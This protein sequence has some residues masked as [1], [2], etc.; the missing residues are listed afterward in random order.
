MP[1]TTVQEFRD[2][3]EENTVA[4]LDDVPKCG[5]VGWF[6]NGGFMFFEAFKPNPIDRFSTIFK[7]SDSLENFVNRAPR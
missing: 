6:G 5:T 2:Y 7:N 4:D 3:I 1:I